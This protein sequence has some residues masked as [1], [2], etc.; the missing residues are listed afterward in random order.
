VRLFD[1]VA[2][3]AGAEMLTGQA[4]EDEVHALAN[5]YQ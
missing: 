5:H 3:Q 2:D 4:E 1:C